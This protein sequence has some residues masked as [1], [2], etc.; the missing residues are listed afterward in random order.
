M[1]F[2]FER[3]GPTRNCTHQS[4]KMCPVVGPRSKRWPSVGVRCVVA[5]VGGRRFALVSWNS[6]RYRQLYPPT[7]PAARKEFR[8]PQACTLSLLLVLLLR[9]P[10]KYVG[11]RAGIQVNLCGLAHRTSCPS[12]SGNKAMK[13]GRP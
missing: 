1:S 9:G 2:K 3:L 11:P 7:Y 4:E 12:L 5:S 6:R 10:T 13:E 8:D